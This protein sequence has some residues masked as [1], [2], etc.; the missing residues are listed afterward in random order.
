MLAGSAGV[1]RLAEYARQGPSGDALVSARYQ[2]RGRCSRLLVRP[3][4]RDRLRR[5]Q[6]CPRGH[7]AF[8]A[9]GAGGRKPLIVREMERTPVKEGE[10]EGAG[11]Q[12]EE[13]ERRKQGW[14]VA[15]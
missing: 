3:W 2:R 12:K 13:A 10:V 9:G 11:G 8:A 14:G 15:R 7:A 5:R 6:K 4:G 1:R